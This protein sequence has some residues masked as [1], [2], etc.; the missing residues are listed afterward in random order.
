VQVGKDALGLRARHHGGKVF[1]S[2][3]AQPRNASEPAQKLLSRPR[4][5][6]GNLQKFAADLAAAAPLP[7]KG[8]GE[9]MRLIP[10]LLY[11][12]QDG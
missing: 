2:E 6:A 8:D 11:E 9:A 12:V 1:H 3:L 4:T 7:V 5:H 10:D